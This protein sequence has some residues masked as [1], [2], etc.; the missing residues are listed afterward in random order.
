MIPKVIHYCW[1]GK[2][3]MPH[4]Q[5]KYIDSWREIMPDYEI[6]EWNESNFDVNQYTFTRQAYDIKLYSFVTDIVRFYALYTEGGI[7]LDTDV[8]AYRPLDKFLNHTIFTGIQVYW[9]QFHSEGKS[10]LDD[11]DLPKNKT[12]IFTQGLALNAAVIGSEKGT[13]YIKECMDYFTNSNFIFPDGS[14]NNTII[15]PAVMADLAIK[16]GFKYRDEDQLLVNGLMVYNSKVFPCVDVD[17]NDNSYLMHYSA[18]SWVPKTSRELFLIKLDK[19][20]L[21]DTYNKIKKIKRIMIK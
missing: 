1:F 8:M 18:Q 21:L 13:P 6:K 20:G 14:L 3:L 11:N 2:G 19:L 9:D 4:S 7:Y 16:Y 12:T 15:N 5:K 17:L 10:Q